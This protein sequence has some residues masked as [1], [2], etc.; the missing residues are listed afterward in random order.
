MGPGGRPQ[1][2]ALLT[3]YSSNSCFPDNLLPF[4]AAHIAA[5]LHLFLGFHMPHAPCNTFKSIKAYL[6]P[7]QLELYQQHHTAAGHSNDMKMACSEVGSATGGLAALANSAEGLL[8]FL[9]TLEAA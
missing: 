4:C 3:S 7:A 2:T 8:R 9:L 5:A 1:L 6:C